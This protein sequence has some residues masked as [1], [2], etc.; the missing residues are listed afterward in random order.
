MVEVGRA[1]TTNSGLS[2]DIYPSLRNYC[3]A[4][5][6]SGM[7][8]PILFPQ[9]LAEMLPI[10]VEAKSWCPLV[11]GLVSWCLLLGRVRAGPPGGAFPHTVRPHRRPGEGGRRPPGWISGRLPGLEDDLDAAILLVSGG[12]LPFAAG[13]NAG[14]SSAHPAGLAKLRQRPALHPGVLP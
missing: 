11:P 10:L 4:S 7:I 2:L 6:H 12:V 9:A 8:R 5:L 3:P 13:Y 1:E 14:V